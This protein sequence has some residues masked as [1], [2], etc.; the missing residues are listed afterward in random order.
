MTNL[1]NLN[2][3]PTRMR[4]PTLA[5]TQASSNTRVPMPTANQNVAGV[6]TEIQTPGENQ[7]A[8]PPIDDNS[9]HIWELEATLT[10][11]ELFSMAVEPETL[12]ALA[13]SIPKDVP[14]WAL[15]GAIVPGFKMD[16]LDSAIPP[17]VDTMFAAYAYIPYSA[18]TKATC[19]KALQG[20]EAVIIM[21]F[22]LS[23]KG[24]DRSSKHNISMLEWMD[25]S[26]V[27]IAQTRHHIGD[28]HT[29]ALR[30]VSANLIMK[31][32]GFLIT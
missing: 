9:T 3:N 22:R 5:P 25:V 12:A 19:I 32:P 4:L 1:H 20:N 23:T 30:G 8:R 13:A 2:L 15:V 24:L 17:K 28:Q 21:A 10:A 26:E 16:V 29:N 7:D 27:H 6:A 18:L 11:V 14:K 31:S